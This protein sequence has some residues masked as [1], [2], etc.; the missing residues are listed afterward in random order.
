MLI[1][2]LVVSLLLLLIAV[3]A[4]R[5]GH[6][7]T[8][9][10]WMLSFLGLA[11]AYTPVIASTTVM[12]QAL[13]TLTAVG[14]WRMANGGPA[15]LVKAVLGATLAAYVV[16]GWF[17]I[18]ETREYA[19]LR[20]LY[21]YESMEAR[22]REPRPAEGETPPG[23]D[24]SARLDRL[25]LELDTQDASGRHRSWQLQRLH[26]NTV[27]LFINSP[28]FGVARMSYPN[29]TVLGPRRAGSPSQP[30]PRAASEGSPG[31]LMPIDPADEAPL[32][33]LLD[34]SIVD[35]VD[36]RGFGYFKDR[37]HVAGFLGH[38]FSEVP[39]AG[40]ER[41]RVR[42]LELVGL[43]LHDE[44]AVYVSD[45]LPSM[46]RLRGAMTRPLDRFEGP[47]LGALRRGDDLFVAR[48]GEA[49]R[50]LGAVRSGR[51]CV[52]CHGGERGALLGAFSYVLGPEE[53]PSD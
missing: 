24:A 52:A 49:V 15:V 30:S 38:G 1:F 8:I 22:V 12:M 20:A 18:H 11:L 10:L 5:R 33:R 40:V 4:A 29:A 7:G 36:E 32:G 43:L 6:Y 16:A 48:D 13:L 35:F 14:V 46:D 17:V 37:R 42:S 19:R 44:P 9:V 23:P 2:S 45:E 50:M 21:P 41:W 3:R 27:G 47:A 53:S 34:E 28:G 31:G 51:Q 25:A 26:E 39:K